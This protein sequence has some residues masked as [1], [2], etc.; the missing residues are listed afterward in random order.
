M[1]VPTA[2]KCTGLEAY[3]TVPRHP[4]KPFRTVLLLCEV[5]RFAQ[6]RLY[7]LA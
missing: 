4:L 2:T 1:I 5:L 6:D 7:F 3:S